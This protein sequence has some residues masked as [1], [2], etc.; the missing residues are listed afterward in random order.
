MRDGSQERRLQDVG[1]AQG[2]RLDAI[3]EQLVAL[4]CS[5]KQGFE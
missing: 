4:Q 3:G 5:G 2:G 1:A